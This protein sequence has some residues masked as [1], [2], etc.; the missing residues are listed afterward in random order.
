MEVLGIVM[1]LAAMNRPTA[2]WLGCGLLRSDA[3]HS[4]FAPWRLTGVV[5]DQCGD[6]ADI[7]ML[8][9]PFR[10]AEGRDAVAVKRRLDVRY[11]KKDRATDASE[12]DDAGGLPRRQRAT[13]NADDACGFVGAQVQTR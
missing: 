5:C 11:G 3:L 12:A 10:F 8:L 1:V 7:D 4:A 2:A 6:R 9:W 13:R